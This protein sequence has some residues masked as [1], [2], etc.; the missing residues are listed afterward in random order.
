MKELNKLGPSTL[1][2]QT[3][4][5]LIELA[6]ESLICLEEIAFDHE[7]RIKQLEKT[8]DELDMPEKTNLFLKACLNQANAFNGEA[9]KRLRKK[10]LDKANS[11]S[12]EMQQEFSRFSIEQIK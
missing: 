12:R 5:R 7:D 4:R 8:I 2:F 11:Y 9:Q 10:V 3:Y 1:E 6:K